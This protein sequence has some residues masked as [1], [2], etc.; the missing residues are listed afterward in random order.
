[1]NWWWR[2]CH[3][4]NGSLIV[5]MR[6]LYECVKQLNQFE[7]S[8]RKWCLLHGYKCVSSAILCVGTLCLRLINVHSSLMHLLRLNCI[9]N[10]NQKMMMKRKSQTQKNEIKSRV[11]LFNIDFGCLEL[12]RSYSFALKIIEINRKW[13]SVCKSTVYEKKKWKKNTKKIVRWLTVYTDSI[14][15]FKATIHTREKNNICMRI[16][17]V[18]WI[19]HYMK[20]QKWEKKPNLSNIKSWQ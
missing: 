12:S 13:A 16:F 2:A 10:G 18:T 14:S 11:I 15:S 1:M 6:L 7:H 5:G 3:N 4:L 19:T 17:G 8:C 20:W 9:I